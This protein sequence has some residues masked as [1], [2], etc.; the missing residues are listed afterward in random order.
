M[1]RKEMIEKL[2]N[3]A[4]ISYE[5]AESALEKNNWD[6]LDAMI[7]LERQ[8]KVN[9]SKVGNAVVLVK[10]SDNEKSDSRKEKCGGFGTMFGRF[11]RFVKNVIHKG[12]RNYFSINKEGEKTIKISLTISSLLLIFAFWPVVIL[13]L[14]GLFFGYK[15]S[16]TGPD[17]KCDKVNDILGKAS[18]S[19]EDIKKDFNEGYKNC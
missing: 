15:Y 14:V 2:M 18:N 19:A 11:C 6:L 10:E 5:E 9:E 12:N 8:G 17:I 1:E 7:Y 3:K 4:K 16:L 13:L